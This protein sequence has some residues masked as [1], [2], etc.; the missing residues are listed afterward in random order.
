MSSVAVVL[1]DNTR[2]TTGNC[3]VV[4]GSA[5]I[6]MEK[7]AELWQVLLTFF[8]S[9]RRAALDHADVLEVTVELRWATLA[10]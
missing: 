6:Y 3:W 4:F 1:R 7:T 9:N 8:R 2:V 10:F 5:S